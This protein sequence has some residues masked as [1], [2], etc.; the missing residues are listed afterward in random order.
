M[1]KYC[2][3]I[4]IH[5]TLIN[6]LSAQSDYYWYRNQK[7]YLEE[8]LTK[9][10][11]LLESVMDSV[12]L[13]R[14]LHSPKTKVHRFDKTQVMSN[15][16]SYKGDSKTEKVWAVIEEISFDKSSLNGRQ[17]ISY[18]APFFKI[19]NGK[20]V[21]LSHLFYVKLGEKNDLI[22]L[23]ELAKK[24]RVEILGNNRF[25][26]LWYTLSCSKHST[27]NALAM[28]N[29][30]YESTFFAAS[31][32]DLMSYDLFT[33]VPLPNDPYFFDQWGLNNTGQYGGTLGIDINLPEVR[34]ITSGSSDIIIAVVDDGV[35]LNHPDQTNMASFSYDANS[36]SNPSVVRGNHGTACAGISG[37][38]TDN[39]LG[40]AGIAPYCPLMSLSAGFDM[41][42][43]IQ[44]LATG[45]EQAWLNGASVISNSWGGLPSTVID[46]AIDDA[47]TLGRGGLGCVVVFAA[48][49][50]NSSVSYPANS[51]PDII[52]VGAVDRCGIRSGR[53]DIIPSSCDPW[54][55]GSSPASSFGNQ[56]DVV[57][58]GSS[59]PTTDRQGTNGYNPFSG[60][61]G[62]YNQFF[63]GT[64]AACPHV[65]AVAGLILSQNP[66]LTM[67]Q[68]GNIIESTAKKVGGYAYSTQVGRPNGT[69]DD[70]VGY[71]L[72]DAFDAVKQVC[73]IQEVTY[74]SQATITVSCSDLE[75]V[76]VTIESGADVTINPIGSVIINGT[77][78][79][80]VGS[81]L[82]MN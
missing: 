20:E 70:E 10:Y 24:H 78:L 45:I 62:D 19:S 25:M 55:P 34:Q 5:V 73:S 32:P 42:N 72:L 74:T 35:E 12:D 47:L 68:V 44:N 38:T 7:I 71:G 54:L 56:L 11:V 57:A 53:I 66:N 63:S 37:A 39:G 21:G 52:A 61:A 9:K 49:N 17:E 27:G 59:V 1:R 79:A 77:F 15:L 22:K 60:T 16:Q 41:P 29:L 3:L 6:I 14:K 51:N 33:T 31:E 13:K 26:P 36:G 28:A 18:Q 81:V 30:F 75:L 80:K 69:W 76:N 2:M 64:S 40:V 43:I 48:G 46:D 65:A 23:E 50:N 58:P 67:Q 4:L 8:I 82:K